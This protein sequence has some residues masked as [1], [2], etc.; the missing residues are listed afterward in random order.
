VATVLLIF[1]HLGK[2]DLHSNNY[3]VLRNASP[4]FEIPDGRPRFVRSVGALTA[5]TLLG[6]SA[7][8]YQ[9]EVRADRPPSFDQGGEFLDAL[10]VAGADGRPYPYGDATA[11][12]A[13]ASSTTQPVATTAAP[14]VTAGPA[15]PT[16]TTPAAPVDPAAGQG[17]TPAAP[18]ATLGA[19]AP[20]PATGAYTYAVSGTEAASGFGSRAFP[21]QATL[22]VHADPSV[23]AGSLVHDLRLSDQHEERSI[24]AY[25]ADGVSYTYEAGS[26][27]FGPGTQ[28]SQ[29]SYEP[30]MVQIPWPLA[31]GASVSGASAARDGSGNVTRTEAWTTTVVGREILDVL[32]TQRETW[33]VDIQRNADGAEKVDRYRRYWYDPTLGIIVQWSERFHGERAMLVTFTF[34]SE[35]TAT[36]TGF[37]PG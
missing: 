8:A 22:V 29:G 23:P 7:A 20:L 25:G 27:T 2:Y 24:V 35:Y 9:L 18:P 6:G 15:G 5:L 34:D 32:G 12:A 17:S 19:A 37:T 21:S 11:A 3:R 14:V 36:L 16:G 28:T 26:V 30:P 13:V 33:V 31:D 10:P 1:G 4:R